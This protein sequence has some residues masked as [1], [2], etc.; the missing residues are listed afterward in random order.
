MV[1]E[2]YLKQIFICDR[3][4]EELKTKEQVLKRVWMVPFTDL[5]ANCCVSQEMALLEMAIMVVEGSSPSV[6]GVW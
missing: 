6:G 4:T 1:I 5:G 3:L 2:L